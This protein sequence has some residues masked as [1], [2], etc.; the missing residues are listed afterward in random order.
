MIKKIKKITSAEL[1]KILTEYDQ[2]VV[3]DQTNVIPDENELL[4]KLNKYIDNQN[5]NDKSVLGID[6]YKYS[7]YGEFE[8]S[9]IP[10]VFKIFLKMTIKL[11]LKNHRYIF[12]KYSSE[13][14]EDY[15]IDA[16]DGGYFI[17]DT[18]LH[19]LLF[20]SNFA[21]VLRTYNSFHLFPKLSKIIGGLSTRY[22]ITYDKIYNFDNNFF[23]R[24]II[25]NARILIK[26]NLNRC[27]ID[28]N[29]HSWFTINME[30][31]EN[32]QIITI[33]DIVNIYEFNKYYDITVLNDYPDEIFSRDPSRIY[34]IINSDILKIGK[35]T[36]KESE[37][38]IYN[39]HLQACIKLVSDDDESR[40]KLITI[41][42]G[43]LNTTGI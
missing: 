16:G 22:A 33:A 9:L 37:L 30:G 3:F 19:S 43:N 13:N 40:Q 4:E 38:N 34:G 14:I 20:A 18:P 12:Q 39:L 36:S 28:Q 2:R 7:L 15:F 8:Q 1:L 5:I 31:F 27:L 32:L 17:F 41:S 10:F 26:D 35:I 42:L 24:A 21:V 6:I 11:C 25:N 29:A 23:G